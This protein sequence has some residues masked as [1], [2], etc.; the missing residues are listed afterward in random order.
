M[1]VIH[2]YPNFD[3]IGG[4]Q[5]IIIELYLGMKQRNIEVK[6]AG[7]TNYG[8]INDR[9]KLKI[10]KSDYIKLDFSFFLKKN[11]SVLISHHRKLTS[12]FVML[13]KFPFFCLSIIHVSHNEFF[14]FK[15]LTFFPKK[16]IAVSEKVKSNLMSVF[17]VDKSR[18]NVIYNGLES[19]KVD[20]SKRDFIKN[21]I[22]KLLYPARI[23]SVKQQ[24]ELVKEIKKSKIQNIKIVFCGDG[25]N[26]N[27]LVQL[28]GNDT[29]FIV[30]GLVENMDEEY[31]NCDFVLLFS[32]NEGLPV[33]LIEACNFSRPIICNDV[34]G[35]L[36]I[37]E[38]NVNG[39]VVNSYS[40]L[41]K[42]IGELK[43]ITKVDYEFLSKNS[44]VVFEKKFVKEIMLNK[45]TQY[46]K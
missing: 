29:R 8:L 30:K 14:D 1:K 34:G 12:F 19:S 5:S 24:L 45:Y 13:S 32:K 22:I 27:D 2:L 16:I 43:K 21:D 15:F 37:V 7:L 35:N 36:E 28:V 39:F 44:K 3:N 10:E 25:V 17:N 31:L 41:I 6:I 4:A 11:D 40:S 9:Y 20:F 26:Y 23:T 18:I 42:R 38:D 46:V 33:S